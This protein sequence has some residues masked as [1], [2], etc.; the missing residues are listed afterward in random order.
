MSEGYV[1]WC[2]GCKKDHAGEC[3]PRDLSHD[4]IEM[5]VTD[6][7]NRHRCKK[8]GETWQILMVSL[9]GA[10]P[11]VPTPPRSPCSGTPKIGSL[12]TLDV[13]FQGAD[14]HRQKVLYQV[15]YNDGAELKVQTGRKEDP[16]YHV[17]PIAAWSEAGIDWPLARGQI[18]FVVP[19]AP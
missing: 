8:C 12:W 14:F 19:G 18:R 5:L 15:V 9:I 17:V 16:I 10:H 7:Q 4:W 2:S 13:K 11:N 6:L 1:F 3:P